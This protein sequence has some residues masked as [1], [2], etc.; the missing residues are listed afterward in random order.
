MQNYPISDLLPQIK[1]VLCQENSLV[2]QAAPGA[3]KTTVV[4]LA[5]MNETWLQGKKIL[6]LEPRRV[7]ARNAAW[8]MA[9]LLG[10]KPGMKIGY[11]VHLESK[12]GPE[13]VIEIVTEGILTK[14]LLHNPEL[15][16]VALVIFDEFHER[17]LDG[18]L[19]LAL[20]QEV[21]EIVREDLKILVMSATLDAEPV[22][23]LLK[24]PV[25]TSEGRAW[26]V[27]TRYMAVSDEKDL[28]RHTVSAIKKALSEEKGSLLVFLPG[29]GEIKRTAESLENLPEDICVRPFY[30]GLSKEEQ[31]RAVRPEKE[32]FRKVVLAT[33]LAESSITI[34]GIRVV[35]DSGYMRSP[36]F[37]PSTGMS[38]L[39]TVRI[40]RASAD[41]RRGRAGRT[42]A[43][44]CYRLWSE[45]EAL[46][47]FSA[48]EITQSDL[49]PMALTLAHWG[50]HDP[51]SLKWLTPPCEK[52]Y[53]QG[54]ELLKMLKAVDSTVSITEHGKKMAGLPMHPRLAHMV[55]MAEE[56]GERNEALWLGTLLSERD[57][58]FSDCD[59]ADIH[60]RLEVLGGKNP[61]NNRI[62]RSAVK[63]IHQSVKKQGG[64][65]L[66][67]CKISPGELLAW[68]Y[69]DRIGKRVSHGSY[70]LSGGR[71][72]R[73]KEDD[74]LA[75]SEYL[76]AAALDGGNKEARIFLAGTLDK[77]FILQNFPLENRKEISMNREKN[78]FYAREEKVLGPLI[79][80]SKKLPAL[81]EAEFHETL[82]HTIKKEGAYLLPWDKS[83]KSFQNR[84]LFLREQRGA[85]WPDSS[86]EALM[87]NLRH[88]LL[89]FL[90]GF[91][92]KNT[93]DTLP[94]LSGLKSLV[95][96][97]LVQE[98]EES[99]PTHYN[100]PS[101]SRLPLTYTRNEVILKVRL[102]ELFGLNET[103]SVLKGSF[104]LTLHLLSPASR[105][106]QIT[107][108]L[109]SFWAG[110][111]SE[112]KKDLK[113]RY[114][115]HYWPD[116]PL[117]A[118]ATRRAKPRKQ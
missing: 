87:E 81:G 30:G 36:R 10:E 24:A 103:P 9:S 20:V 26:P 38:R 67:P 113:G 5:L 15:E 98:M 1:A 92:L 83:S 71:G 69:P 105:P 17:H 77:E 6:I 97:N 47:E 84:L 52:S 31:D 111:Y 89:P 117:E 73:L 56:R 70:I 51:A 27:E 116:N 109:K 78:R 60:L 12:V 54:V 76:V 45:K 114:P 68:A 75:L 43:G 28:I 79:L 115:K 99:A 55:I 35:I 22:A 39:E 19:G 80:S 82:I 102:Q 29:A 61:Y 72:A 48:P 96:W 16:D 11:R 44:I 93:L 63:R 95:P 112:V 40:S 2:L 53:S 110:A 108:D 57:I 34:E 37:N 85:D 91:T 3:G 14:K 88:W 90:H 42:M 101:G 50:T 106:I 66:N 25:V 94:L 65:D 62:D 46:E 18:D 58:L 32:G 41:Q 86:D 13:T 64:K 23:R 118:E 104:P 59:T 8:R 107:R 4:P 21:Q 74:P 7:A 100:A 33:N 49:T